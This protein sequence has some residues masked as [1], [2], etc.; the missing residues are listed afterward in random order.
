LLEE[1]A[2]NVLY[3]GSNI[4]ETWNYLGQV[5]RSSGI[6]VAAPKGFLQIESK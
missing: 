6:P 5:F 1:Q 2:Q 4:K 3:S